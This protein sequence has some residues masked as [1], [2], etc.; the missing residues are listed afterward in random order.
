MEKTS[1]RIL[2][3][4]SGEE[5]IAK[6][7]GQTKDKMI[8]E[9]PMIFLHRYMTDLGGRE[10][11]LTI[12]KSWLSHTNEREAKIPKD[13]IATFLV[14]DS[15]V[16]DLYDLEKEKEDTDNK[17]PQRIVNM[18][19]NIQKNNMND[20]DEEDDNMINIMKEMLSEYPELLNDIKEK[21]NIDDEDNNGDILTPN[22]KN[23]ITMTMF[24]PPE[25]LISLVDADLLDIHDIQ[26]LIDTLGN[27]DDNPNYR[28]NDRN[29]QKEED[30][31]ND[32][33]DWS[34]NLKD[35]FK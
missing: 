25:A 34:P 31:G 4:R 13:H 16:I 33:T 21:L 19:E 2:K 26:N 23:F 5:I 11:E 10:R 20:E 32:W 8:I 17:P 22:M 1:Y 27:N 18:S 15:D 24:F 14:P 9:R 6:I 29:R 30:F 7:N 3:L 28:G 12:L 35:Y